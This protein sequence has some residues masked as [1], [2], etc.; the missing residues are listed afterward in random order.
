MRDRCDYDLHE[1]S[2]AINSDSAWGDISCAR[3]RF[4]LLQTRRAETLMAAGR[5]RETNHARLVPSC[6]P[7][8]TCDLPADVGEARRCRLLGGHG[9]LLPPVQHHQPGSSLLLF[10]LFLLFLSV[11][12]SFGRTSCSGCR[13]SRRGSSVPCPCG[14]VWRGEIPRCALA[15]SRGARPTSAL[16]HVRESAGESDT[17]WKRDRATVLFM[18][19]TNKIMLVNLPC[20]AIQADMVYHL[21]GCKD[22]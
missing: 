8:L 20:P 21:Q 15:Q 13:C 4:Q 17:E 12:P 5:R 19:C 22:K 18:M 3:Q 9:A 14:A 10:L 7:E 11:P 1:L 2:T 6:F 16:K